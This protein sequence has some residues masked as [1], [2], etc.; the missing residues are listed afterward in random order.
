MYVR[1]TINTT[2]HCLSC[3]ETA[4]TITYMNEL[5]IFAHNLWMSCLRQDTSCQCLYTFVN[6]AMNNNFKHYQVY[7]TL[8][9]Q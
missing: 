9:S 1:Y 5:P 8:F 3:M 2:Q 7:T 6:I 4:H